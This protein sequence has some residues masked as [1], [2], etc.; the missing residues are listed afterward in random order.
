MVRRVGSRWGGW[1]VGEEESGNS[2]RGV[3][4]GVS[5]ERAM[6]VSLLK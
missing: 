2:R 6:K 5:E 4:E 3:G 1:G